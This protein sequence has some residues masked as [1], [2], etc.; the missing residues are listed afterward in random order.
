MCIVRNFDLFWLYT[1]E[2]KD[3]LRSIVDSLHTIKSILHFDF[4]DKIYSLY[5]FER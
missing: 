5:K 1:Y 4:R 2:K 3:L